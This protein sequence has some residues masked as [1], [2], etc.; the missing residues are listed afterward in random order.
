MAPPGPHPA[1]ETWGQTGCALLRG[2]FWGF[3]PSLG[4]PVGTP[5]PPFGLLIPSSTCSV[6]EPSKGEMTQGDQGLGS[7]SA[8]S[9]MWVTLHKFFFCSD[10]ICQIGDTTSVLMT[11]KK[12]SRSTLKISKGH[13]KAGLLLAIVL[14]WLTD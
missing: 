4:T 2:S 9:E 14:D 12:Q 10:L 3:L 8:I 11:F 6:L 7:R 1:E 13:T 5:L